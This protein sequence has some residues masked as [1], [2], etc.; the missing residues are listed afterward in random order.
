MPYDLQAHFYRLYGVALALLPYL[1]VIFAAWLISK[2]RKRDSPVEK[3]CDEAYE[4]LERYRTEVLCIT[5]RIEA[6]LRLEIC[7][8]PLRFGFGRKARWSKAHRSRILR[9][10]GEVVVSRMLVE[11]DVLLDHLE[12]LRINARVRTEE[13]LLQELESLSR[14]NNDLTNVGETICDD[15]VWLGHRLRKLDN[16]LREMESAVVGPWEN[17]VRGSYA[18]VR[19]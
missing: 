12:T 17:M 15:F 14:C 9:G 6:L 8:A 13:E 7:Y 3:R 16:T 18:Q 10:K 4:L 2:P 11:T 5:R 1:I 19:R